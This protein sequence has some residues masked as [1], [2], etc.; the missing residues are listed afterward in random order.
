MKYFIFILFLFGCTHTVEYIP[1]KNYCPK[2]QRVTTK[3]ANE[4]H[5]INAK[6]TERLYK[7]T[8]LLMISLGCDYSNPKLWV[9]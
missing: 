9:D 3:D 6:A 4:L 5:S 2:L 1:S 8:K 7:N